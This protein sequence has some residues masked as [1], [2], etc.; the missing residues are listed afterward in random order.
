MRRLEGKLAF[1]GGMLMFIGCISLL[2]GMIHAVSA[3]WVLLNGG[4]AAEGVYVPD[5]KGGLSIRYEADGTAYHTESTLRGT[6]GKRVPVHYPPNA[7][8]KGVVTDAEAWSIPLTAG[9][10]FAGIGAAFMA[11][12]VRYSRLMKDLMKNGISVEAQITRIEKSRWW[13]GERTYRIHAALIHPATG[14]QINVRSGEL[15]DNPERYLLSD[16]VTVFVDRTDEKRYCMLTDGKKTRGY[17][18][19]EIDFHL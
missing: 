18:K 14:N 15:L 3:A 2:M 6:E 4:A 10:A 9:A 7:P 16:T 5:G 13:I 1:M 12:N 11:G 17:Q 19:T 8:E